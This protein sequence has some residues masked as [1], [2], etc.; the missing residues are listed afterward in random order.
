MLLARDAAAPIAVLDW[1]EARIMLG[2]N[3]RDDEQIVSAEE[4]IKEVT[5]IKEMNPGGVKL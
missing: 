4:W 3:A 1:I 2:K 5:G